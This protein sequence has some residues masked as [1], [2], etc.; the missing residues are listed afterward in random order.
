MSRNRLGLILGA[1]LLMIAV[2][3]LGIYRLF[4]SCAFSEGCKESGLCTTASG[5]CIAGS[6]DECRKSEDCERK[7][8]CHLSAERCVAGTDHDC[9]R[10]VW[11]KERGMCSLEGEDC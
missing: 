1:S 11:C 3:A 10:S 4:F 6:V 5:A 9:R 7:G 8:R 2:I